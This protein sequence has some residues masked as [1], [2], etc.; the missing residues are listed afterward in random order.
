M[1][2]ISPLNRY[3][4]APIPYAGFADTLFDLWTLPLDV[5]DPEHPG[6]GKPELFLRTPFDE[7]EPAFSP[8]GRWIA[9]TSSE[10]GRL[11]V[12]VR[13]FPRGAPAGSGKWQIST[14]GG[15]HPIW[16]RDGRELFYETLEGIGPHRSIPDRIMVSTYATKADS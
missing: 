12:Y 4:L 9:S 13:P 1:E 14:G 11:E 3:L 16:S 6:P 8:D 2:S 7:Y 10:S 5:S 15:V